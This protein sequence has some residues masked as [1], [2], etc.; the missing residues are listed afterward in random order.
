M[1]WFCWF[2]HNQTSICSRMRV[3]WAGAP[4]WAI[5][6]FQASGLFNGECS[7]TPSSLVSSE[8]LSSGNFRLPGVAVDR[9]HNCGGL[10][11]QRRGGAR[12]PTLL[13]MATKLLVWCA[14]RQVSLTAKFV[15]GKLNVLA[16]SLSRKGQIIHTEWTLRWGTLSQIF[17]FWEVPHIDLFATRLNNQLPTFVSPFHDPLAW[18]VDAMSLSWEGM[19]AYAFP[20][21]PLLLKVL[22]KMEKETCL[23]MLGKSP[24]LSSAVSLLVAP[25]IKLPCRRDLL[26]QPHSHLTHPKPE[27]FNLHT[28]LCCRE[29]WRRQDFLKDLPRESV[30]LKELPHSLSTIT[31]GTLGWIGVS[32]GRWIPSIHL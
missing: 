27:I 20:P 3:W 10:S 1:L 18:A 16:D 32:N 22:L 19:L 11:E 14:K 29:V 12:S 28:W 21:I 13:F 30:P 8:V 24:V 4:I 7:G 17:H 9:Q 31:V 15:P 25:A 5:S 6:Q 26:I 23:V 2:I